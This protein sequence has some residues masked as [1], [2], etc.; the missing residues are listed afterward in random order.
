MDVQFF[1]LYLLLLSEITRIT[2]VNLFQNQL[3]FYRIS[4]CS[5]QLHKC[6]QVWISSLGKEQSFPPEKPFPMKIFQLKWAFFFFL[7][8]PKHSKLRVKSCLMQTF[9]PQCGCTRLSASLTQ[10]RICP[11]FPTVR[12]GRSLQEPNSAPCSCYPPPLFLLPHFIQH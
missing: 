7:P 11:H 1:H 10:G 9:I 3:Y 4:F 2:F 8:L 6:F 12:W 5:Y